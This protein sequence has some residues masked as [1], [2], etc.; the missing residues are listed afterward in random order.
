MQTNRNLLAVEAV[1]ATAKPCNRAM[2]Y[3]QDLKTFPSSGDSN[4]SLFNSAFYNPAQMWGT[5]LV[6][7]KKTE[8]SREEERG[9]LLIGLD[10]LACSRKVCIERLEAIVLS[11][12]LPEEKRTSLY[13]C[14]SL[15]SCHL[16]TWDLFSQILQLPLCSRASTNRR[17]ATKT[18]PT[19]NKHQGLL[20]GNGDGEID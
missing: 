4:Q 16:A 18:R 20:C 8:S 6:C 5:Q 9:I 1:V 12:Y 14:S 2:H 15:P 7:N 3:L 10:T 13:A 11:A 19:H 17:V